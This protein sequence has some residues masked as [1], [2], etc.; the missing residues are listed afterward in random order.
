MSEA[1]PVPAAVDEGLDPVAPDGW[2]LPCDSCEEDEGLL[3]CEGCARR[4]CPD[5]WGADERFCEE[6]TGEDLQR[7]VETVDANER[8]L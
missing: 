5:C 8:Y 1:P 2:L 4:L 7:P 3:E 6:C